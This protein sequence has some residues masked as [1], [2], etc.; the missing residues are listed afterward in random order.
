MRSKHPKVRSLIGATR[1]ITRRA[2]ALP[3]TALAVAAMLAL[4]PATAADVSWLGG[5]GSWSSAGSWL[6]GVLPGFDDVVRIDNGNALSSNVL[7]DVSASVQSLLV[8][9]GDVMSVGGGYSFAA[10][11]GITNRG[12]IAVNGGWLLASAIDNQAALVS[13]ATDSRLDLGWAGSVSGGTIQGNHSGWGARPLVNGGTLRGSTFDGQ[14]SIDGDTRLDNF[15]VN[16]SGLLELANASLSGLIN[17]RGGLI[18]TGQALAFDHI[19]LY[20]TLGMESFARLDLGSTGSINGGTIRGNHS[21]WGERPLV[22]GGSLS[23]THLEGTLRLQNVTLSNATIAD[24]ASIRIA[25]GDT[26]T[27]SGTTTNRGTIRLDDG[28]SIQASG[29]FNNTGGLVDI[30]NGSYVELAAG[31]SFH[32]GTVRGTGTAALRGNGSYSDVALDGTV[33]I[34]G[35]NFSNVSLASTMQSLTVVAN[36]SLN[37]AGQNLAQTADSTMV[38]NGSLTVDT[39]TLDAGTLQGSGTIHGDVVNNGGV[40]AAGNSPGTLTID[41]D[42]TLGDDSLILVEA[43]GL[44][45]GS[46]YDWLSVVGNATLDGDVQFNIDYAAA[47]GDT[48]TFLSTQTGTVS[49]Q[50]DHVLA[51]GYTLGVS[52]SA[53][54][55]DVQITGVSAVP[56]PQ[57]WVLMLSGVG[58]ML[59]LGLRGGRPRG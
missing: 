22:N 13:I 58:L 19:D 28:S 26:V 55:V 24:A 11:S 15:T 35:G 36:G 52:Y 17:V 56:E 38:V 42:L 7:L 18:V 48:F 54:G 10:A 39:L 3:R 46:S 12:G 25:T 6:G 30:G 43:Y 14:V 44:A 40:I 23:D 8:D 37:L 5:S 20:G 45:Q 57:S 21:G 50:F 2:G 9:S 16:E 1:N 32:G 47:I 34:Q 41:G 51:N 59:W 27:V 4:N 31:G 29:E 33:A 49:G 53:H